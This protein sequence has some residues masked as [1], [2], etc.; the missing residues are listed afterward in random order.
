MSDNNALWFIGG[1]IVGI[2]VGIP[3]GFYL[4]NVFIEKPASVV[5]ERDSEGRITGIHYVSGR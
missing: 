3:L 4:Y 1:F 5:F 2:F